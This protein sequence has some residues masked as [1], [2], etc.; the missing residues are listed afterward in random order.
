GSLDLV[1]GG[2]IGLVI[3][4]FYILRQNM[5]IPYY[6]HRSSYSNGD[7][8]KLTLAQEVSFLNKASIKETLERLPPGRKVII[9][10]SKTEY[11]DFDV[12]DIIRDFFQSKEPTENIKLSLVVFKNIYNIPVAASEWEIL[13]DLVE[14]DEVPQ[15]SAGN[16]RKL[17]RQLGQ[18]GQGTKD[19]SEK[20][21]KKSDG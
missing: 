9:D 18:N 6:Y 21:H 19:K 1:K 7:L 20:T 16:H 15:R 4:I 10:A 3:S 2:G 12:L 8:I 13:S 17:L 5:G 14:T 11:I